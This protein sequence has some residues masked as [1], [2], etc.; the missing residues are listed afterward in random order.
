MIITRVENHWPMPDIDARNELLQISRFC[1][2][3]IETMEDEHYQYYL[4]FENTNDII[5]DYN[6]ITD[7]FIS[8]GSLEGHD[9][10]TSSGKRVYKDFIT[11]ILTPGKKIYPSD[12]DK[13]RFFMDG[14]LTPIFI[15]SLTV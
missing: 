13:I 12:V 1:P 8:F 15:I 3:D 6:F 10:T 7:E 9:T 4:A 14:K 5:Y 11:T 2:I